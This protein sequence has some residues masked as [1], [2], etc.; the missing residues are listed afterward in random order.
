MQFIC[1][2]DTGCFG[3]CWNLYSCVHRHLSTCMSYFTCYTY[4]SGAVG[5]EIT[6]S[7]D[8]VHVAFENVSG[9]CTFTCSGNGA[10]VVWSVDGLDTT[11]PHV[12]NKGISALTSVVSPDGRNITSRL[13]VPTIKSNNNTSVVCTMLDASYRNPQSAGPVT[14]LIQGI[15]KVFLGIS[16][17]MYMYMY[18]IVFVEF[19]CAVRLFHKLEQVC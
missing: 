19:S 14:L 8:Q 6:P 9:I 17:Y 5:I 18:V 11:T 2:G 3:M 10:Y 4:T 1:K 12:V 7:K 16:M 15:I 13:S